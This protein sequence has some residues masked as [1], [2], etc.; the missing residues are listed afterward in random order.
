[1]GRN[2]N[3]LSGSKV[4]PFSS[5]CRC[6]SIL[7]QVWYTAALVLGRSQL[8]VIPRDEPVLRDSS[9]GWLGDGIALRRGRA[10][11]GV[12]Q[13]LLLFG[14]RSTSLIVGDNPGYGEREDVS[15]CFW[16]P[17]VTGTVAKWSLR[18]NVRAVRKRGFMKSVEVLSGLVEGGDLDEVDGPASVWGVE[19]VI[20]F[21]LFFFLFPSSNRDAV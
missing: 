8:R 20:V 15:I 9:L 6:S 3:G 11:R 7:E 14:N 10:L 17:G 19:D 1:M 12:E 16:Q 2:Y 21:F 18:G 4:I 13:S 5:S